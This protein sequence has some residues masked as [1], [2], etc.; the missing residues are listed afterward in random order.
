MYFYLINNTFYHFSIW[1]IGGYIAHSLW[2]CG[3]P[4]RQSN[5]LPKCGFVAVC[6]QLNK[7][8]KNFWFIFSKYNRNG[9]Q[10]GFSFGKSNRI[11]PSS[12]HTYFYN[13]FL[14]FLH[15]INLTGRIHTQCTEFNFIQF[16]TLQ[17]EQKKTKSKKLYA[18]KSQNTQKSLFDLN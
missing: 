6:H 10:P 14:N 1:L 12:V 7:Q 18:Q 8:E 16:K 5:Y 17:F 2:S 4:V 15:C 13:L 9:L 3:Y 11:N